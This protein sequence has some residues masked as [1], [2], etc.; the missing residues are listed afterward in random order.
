[1]KKIIILLIGCFV[2]F[3]ACEEKSTTSPTQEEVKDL[4]FTFAG[5]GS[6]YLLLHTADGQTIEQTLQLQPNQKMDMPDFGAT[7]VSFTVIPIPETQKEAL[8]IQTVY[9]APL[10]DFV[11]HTEQ[12]SARK[13]IYVKMETSLP[14]FN[15]YTL[16]GPQFS[17]SYFGQGMSSVPATPVEIPMDYPEVIYGSVSDMATGV[18]Q[19]GIVNLDQLAKVNADT[20]TIT[21]DQFLK[22]KTI[23][24][25]KAG[26]MLTCSSVHTTTDGKEFSITQSSQYAWRST[27]TSWDAKYAA[28]V[29]ADMYNIMIAS[30]SSSTSWSMSVTASELPGSIEVP[31]SH[32]TATPTANGATNITK[33]GDFDTFLCSYSDVLQARPVNWILYADADAESILF[34]AIPEDV[35]QA[36]NLH[37]MDT[38]NS[39]FHAVD[40]DYLSGY[41][42]FLENQ[43]TQSSSSQEGSAY[44][45]SRSLSTTA[46]AKPL[47]PLTPFNPLLP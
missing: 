8:N 23:E 19:Y 36:V 25:S 30:T 27:L 33:L 35:K 45:V 40:V 14:T 6:A 21:A 34:P 46:L 10:Q 16:S 2:F 38:T 42:D 39:Q 20:L 17:N 11:F 4:S 5:E 37:K 24:S 29:P 13:T 31:T 41:G 18:G 3:L 43:F 28:T 12:A 47:Q 1:M 32:V 22:T 15:S 26:N 9:N 7:R 44:S